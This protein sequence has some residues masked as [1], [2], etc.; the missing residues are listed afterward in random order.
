MGAVQLQR[1]HA[2]IKAEQQ[3][4]LQTQARVVAEN[5]VRQLRGVDSA[6]RGLRADLTAPSAAQAD[7]VSPHR[8]N[9]LG[10]AMPGVR[11]IV[12]LDAQGR[13]TVSEASVL[14]GQDFASR[15]YFRAPRERPDYTSLYVSPPF[16]STRGVYSINLG[17]AVPDV[18]GRFNGVISANLDPEYFEI[19]ARSVLY[20]PDMLVSVIHG[21]GKPFIDLH[22]ARSG[23]G[24]DPAQHSA[25]FARHI[26]SERSE[27]IAEDE[28]AL[29][30]D[31]R[32]V[33]FRTVFPPELDMDTPLVV[34]VSRSTR[35][36]YAPWRDDVRSLALL[37]VLLCISSAGTLHFVQQRRQATSHAANERQRL[38]DISA[39]QLR[40]AAELQQRT[41]RLAKVGGWQLEL[42]TQQM[43]WTDEMYEIHDVD[44]QAAL[45][46]GVALSPYTPDARRLVESAM[47]EAIQ[48]GT[49]WSLEARVVTARGRQLWVRTQG[50]AIVENGR[51][52]RLIG[53]SQDVT[54]RVR[55]A[56]ELQA[57]N[58][59]LERLTVTDGL[60]GVGNRRLFDQKL[61]T[62]WTRCARRGLD[63]GLLMVDIDH[64]KLYNDHYGHQ[65][66]DAVLRQ[67]ATILTQCVQRSGELVA[68]YGGE[69]F[70]VLL[71]GSDMES[72]SIVA[73]LFLAQLAQAAI[74]HIASSTAAV[75]TMSIG[76]ASMAP[77]ATDQPAQLIRSA[78]SALYIAKHLGRNRAEQAPAVAGP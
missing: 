68:R 50:E 40:G 3:N 43:T 1:N 45:S 2:Q 57:A 7:V 46:R 61:A 75:L 51:V 38:A 5:L 47:H 53:A 20:A 27:T 39:E 15:E 64:F 26:A 55:F 18:H 58:E 9:E 37:F 24:K 14:E 31:N 32:M 52:V 22:P 16:T 48:H 73:D 69:E 25:S 60:T 29:T 54:E 17:I 59:K 35:E 56:T 33:V 8:L 70:A 11:G 34:S 77:V 78:D 71:P 21:D 42:A 44:R 12:V 4:R 72:A 6:L 74:P 65:G 76:V 67:V 28:D 19:V 13:I 30:H 10:R 36:V 63:L 62:E 23:H 41:G 66:G 49:P